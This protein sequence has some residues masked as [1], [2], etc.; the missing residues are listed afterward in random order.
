M[1][2]IFLLE[3]QRKAKMRDNIGKGQNKNIIKNENNN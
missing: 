2:A 1:L 3:E